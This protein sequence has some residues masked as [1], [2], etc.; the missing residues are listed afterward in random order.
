MNLKVRFHFQPTS[1]LCAKNDHYDHQRLF[2]QY[3]L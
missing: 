3:E 1:K 2:P